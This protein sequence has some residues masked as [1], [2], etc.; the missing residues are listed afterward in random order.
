MT[1]IKIL[2][3][4]GGRKVGDIVDLAPDAATYLVEAGYAEQVAGKAGQ[5]KRAARTASTTS[6]AEQDEESSDES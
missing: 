3:E 6:T 5:P 2:S 1:N 4:V